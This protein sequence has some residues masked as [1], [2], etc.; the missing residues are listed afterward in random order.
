MLIA[1]GRNQ[2]LAIKAGYP[3]VD[4]NQ[5]RHTAYAGYAGLVN[6]AEQ[7][8]NGMRFYEGVQGPG[9]RVQGEKTGEKLET[10]NPKLNHS[11]LI[12]PLKHSPAI[13]AAMA[14]QGI[15]GALPIIHG[16]Q[17]CTFLGKVLLT[18]HFREPI[19][20][21]S[22]KLF[23]EDVVMGS[24][25]KL[26][27][28]IDGFIEKND[29]V[30]V[31]VLTS[32]LSEVKGDDVAQVARQFKI[33]NSK[34][35]VIHVATADYDGGLETGYAR[36]VEAIVQIADCGFP[37]SIGTGLLADCKQVNILAGS[38][39]TPAD[40]TEIREIVADFG[41]RA[42]MLPDL[43]ALDG[44]RQD[45]SPLAAGGTSMDDVRRMGQSGLTLALGMSMEPAAKLLQQKFGIEYQVFESVA[46]LADS[47]RLVETL[48]VV[49]G[50]PV[51]AGL[52][53]QRRVLRDAMR[54][55]HFFFGGKKICIAL[56]P[57]LAAQTSK[58][59]DEM[60][61]AP[62]LAIIPTLSPAADHIRARDVQI[63]DLFSIAG[64]FDLLIASSHGAG[65]AKRLG[66]PLYEMGF[67]VYKSLGYTSKVLI[68][69][70]GTTALIN[71]VGS[72]LM[73]K[74]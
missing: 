69:Y 41:M 51:P 10:R 11:V 25:D 45:F 42:I 63:G 24:E 17:G 34:V 7:I 68:G 31:G 49:S 27:A 36:A 39:L 55:A 33:Q 1:G 58:W 54:D 15:D 56:E 6:L 35:K 14:L 28:V 72:L 2:Y 46:G 8:S 57:D 73:K 13:G 48:S 18:K 71:E 74:H 38:H 19:A 66:V 44:S 32:G 52:E 37:D 67:P 22:S 29:P 60:G 43:S 21:A 61:A 53:R 20:L 30:L 64:D 59:L 70:C 5:E 23:V 9:S 26:S 47:D 65:T 62:E 12:N 3:F 40:F 4:V 16:A 50:K